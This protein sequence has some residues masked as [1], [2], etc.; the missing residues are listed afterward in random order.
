[1]VKLAASKCALRS[2]P[3]RRL[4]FSGHLLRRTQ[5]Q[6]QICPLTKI[7]LFLVTLGEGAHVVL[8]LQALGEGA[9]VILPL[10]ALGQ[11]AHVV[12]L[13]E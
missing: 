11:G 7:I 2:L 10:Q 5:V 3:C 9:H 8:L 12:L 6:L 4:Y 13:G 1:M